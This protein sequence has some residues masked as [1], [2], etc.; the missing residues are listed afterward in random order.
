MSIFAQRMR[1]LR[2]EKGRTQTQMAELI[3]IKLRAYQNYESGTSYPEIP[4]LMKL[5]DYFDVTTDYLLGRSEER[6]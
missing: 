6:K 2:H 4:N 5:A 1:E 3:G